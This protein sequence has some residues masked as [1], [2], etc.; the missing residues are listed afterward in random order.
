M[1]S[2]KTT[3][4]ILMSLSMLLLVCSIA[5]SQTTYYSRQAGTWNNNTNVW[6][7]V[8]QMGAACSC[9]PSGMLGGSNVVYI[10]NNITATTLSSLSGAAKIIVESGDSAT[11][12]TTTLSLSGSTSIT[13]NAGGTLI[14]NG[15]LNMAGGTTIT[16]NGFIAINGSVTNSGSASVVNNGGLYIYGNVSTSGGAS[17]SGTGTTYATG[18][19]SGSGTSGISTLTWKNNGTTLY[20]NAGNVG[21]GTSNP[22][23]PLQIKGQ[24]VADSGYFHGYVGS[25]GYNGDAIWLNSGV[26][27][28]PP[29]HDEINTNTG[30]IG[31]ISRKFIGGPVLPLGQFGINTQTPNYM[32]DVNETTNANGNVFR[33][34]GNNAYNADWEAW[35]GPSSLT[36]AG[37]T[38]KGR[39]YVP[40]NTNN[41]AIEA[42]TNSPGPAL[43]GGNLQ[44]Y[45]PDVVFP[46]N[47]LRMQ[48]NGPLPTRTQQGQIY[49]RTGYVGLNVNPL[50]QNMPA[51]LLTLDG[52]V[53]SGGDGFR[54]WMKIGAYIGNNSDNMYVGMIDNLDAAGNVIYNR[55]DAAIAWGNDSTGFGNTGP[56]A[57]RF[58][59]TNYDTTT[60]GYVWGSEAGRWE[61]NGNLGVGDFRVSKCAPHNRIEDYT[62]LP[63]NFSYTQWLRLQDSTGQ[64][65][66]TWK[67]KRQG[68][69]GSH[70]DMQ[71]DSMGD[72]FINAQ[73]DS[74][75]RFTGVGIRILNAKTL[76][77]QTPQNTLEVMSGWHSPYY[78]SGNGSSGLKFRNLTSLNKPVKNPGPGILSLDNAGNVIYVDSSAGGGGSGVGTCAIPT[79]YPSGVDG[80]INLNNNNNFY[81]EGNN[82]TSAFDNIFMG[83]PCATA[84]LAK[85]NVLQQSGSNNSIGIYVENDDL[86]SGNFASPTSLIGIKS[87]IP[88]HAPNFNNVYNVAG[89]FQAP[90]VP[91]SPEQYGVFIPHRGG[92]ISVG[93]PLGTLTNTNYLLLVGGDEY[94]SGNSILGNLTVTNTATINGN[95][96]T[97]GTNY[98]SNPSWTSSDSMFKTNLDTIGNAL[99]IVSKLKPRTYYF[100]SANMYKMNFESTKQYGFIAQDVQNVLPSIVHTV[101]KPTSYDSAGNVTA[102]GITFKAL[103]YN[104]FA[105]ILTSAVQQQ[106]Q[107]I[108]SLRNKPSISGSGTTNYVPKFTAPGTLGN[109]LLFDNGTNI[110]VGTTTPSSTFDVFTTTSN[111][112]VLHNSSN[113]NNLQ[114]SI[115]ANASNA[116]TMDLNDASGNSFFHIAYTGSGENPSYIND[117]LLIG[118]NNNFGIHSIFEVWGTNN[119]DGI[120]LYNTANANQK[121][122]AITSGHGNDGNIDAFDASGAQ[123]L[124]I[125]ANGATGNYPYFNSHFVV[126]STWGGGIVPPGII[127]VSNS[128]GTLGSVAMYASSTAMGASVNYGIYATAANATTNYAGYFNGDVFVNGGTNSG[129]GYLVASDKMFK[130]NITA[131]TN[132]ISIINQL[133]PSTFYFDT[134][135]AY[136]M[137]FSN[138]KQYGFIAQDV[139]TVLPD[140][141]STTTKPAVLDSIGD[142]ITHAVTYKNLNYSEFIALLTNGMQQQQQTID[143]LRNVLN[144]IQSCLTALCDSSHGS[145]HAIHN[146]PGAG[147]VNTI[148]G[149]DNTID[150][151]LS[152]SAILYQ[153]TP[154][155]F[156]TGTKINYFLPEGTMGAMIVFFDM[157]GSK[158]KEVILDK[159][160]AGTINVTPDNLANGMYSY[161]LIINGQVIDT[162]KMVLSR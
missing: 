33:T 13:V 41:F 8:S 120:N 149:S 143:S 146:N 116:A 153:N 11:I 37:S 144:S 9:S 64:F 135:N 48:I 65:R 98:S 20:Y 86:A 136:N 55:S 54:P 158:M 43:G 132:A 94:V 91:N 58:I 154:N 155:P 90:F 2:R 4:G 29:F 50:S 111:G 131:I 7:T 127:T 84:P 25:F 35:T 71:V 139:Q 67:S 93:Y 44:F 150:V 74:T 16:N 61:P 148:N 51:S 34:A 62:W 27:A 87:L 99:A 88:P 52:G 56:D 18:T 80:A 69:L 23:A 24:L 78:A 21:I 15:A 63:G 89:W 28:P 137:H 10:Y 107:S 76:A 100:D 141:I 82:Q 70:T 162:K 142:T 110:G 108:D 161:S 77:A 68:M 160:G 105:A 85:L 102:P 104:Q 49:N 1:K 134:A 22:T 31:V 46:P 122:V 73:K 6:S 103:D 129:T 112:I 117:K 119:S 59:F 57:L 72:L 96:Y 147:S 5:K 42:S 75:P 38:M 145:H 40:A 128:T 53:I 140:L 152:N 95:L 101:V 125:C 60:V 3:K 26:A 106:Q 79:A 17:F 36:L 113:S 66:L 159:T 123:Y 32:L 45:T 121:T 138:K 115:L 19:I 47:V 97:Y 39:V 118:T 133:K 81:F 130:T 151:T 109:S 30:I 83:Y 126:G 124:H 157:Y 92:I 114:A 12:T 156:S 14:L